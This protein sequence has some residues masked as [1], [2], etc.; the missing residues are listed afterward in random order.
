[1]GSL[2]ER[3]QLWS[4]WASKYVRS[5]VQVGDTMGYFNTCRLPQVCRRIYADTAIVVYERTNF[6]ILIAFGSAE[7]I[8]KNWLSNR[9]PYQ[10]SAIRTLHLVGFPYGSRFNDGRPVT[11]VLPGLKTLRYYCCRRSNYLNSEF[12]WNF[13]GADED[14]DQVTKAIYE[15]EGKGVE[16]TVHWRFS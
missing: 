2:S 8:W 12:N 16:V 10:I 14:D 13:E 15:R 6:S 1:M 7:Q 3:K 4:S 11:S 5:P 9:L